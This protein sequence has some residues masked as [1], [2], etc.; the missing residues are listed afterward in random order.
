K[1][2]DAVRESWGELTNEDLAVIDGKR[3]KFISCIQDKYGLA[4]NEAE[5]RVRQ[6]QRDL[7]ISLQPIKSRP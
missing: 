6:W 5:S 1:L 4:R 2:R 7:R 3:E